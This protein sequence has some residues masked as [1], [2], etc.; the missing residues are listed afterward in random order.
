MTKARTLADITIPSGTPVG[1]TDTQ[2]LTNKTIAF[3][4]N[5]LTDVVGVTATQ[6]LTNKTLTAPT[7]ASANLTTALTVAGASGTSGQVLTSGGSGAAPTW[8]SVSSGNFGTDL[9]FQDYSLTLSSGITTYAEET[10]IMQAVSLDGT[11]ELMVL[12]GS[13]SAHAVVF[14]T[15]T[16]TFG[17]PVLVRTA[18]LGS[19]AQNV[20][21]AK[22]SSTSVLVCSLPS[23]NTGLET[24]VLTIS[25]STI[26]VGTPVST[27]LAAAS[28]L[29]SPNTRLVTV[30]SSY[31]LNYYN[32]T[33]TAPKFRAITV[34]GSTPSIGS[35]LA[36]AG[37]TTA[38]M[39][40][41][42]AQSAS[43]LLSF[44][45]TTST[46]V[47]V[48]PITV[49]GTTLTAGTAATVSTTGNSIV[50]GA[51]SNS[52]YALCYINTTG[53][54]AVVSVAGTTASISTAGTTFTVSSFAPQM[55]VFGNQA[56]IRGGQSTAENTNVITDTSGTATLGTNLLQG[57]G[58]FFVGYLSTSKVLLSNATS[59]DSD[60]YQ[61]G[62]SSGSPVLEKSFQN[63]SNSS[64][65]STN[66]IARYGRPLSGPP[67][68][69][70]GYAI[71][72][73]TSAGK[74]AT[75]FS[76]TYP[77]TNSIDGTNPPK[78]QQSAN[79]FSAYNDGISEAVAWGIPTS[80]AASTTAVQIRKVTLA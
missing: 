67:Q 10:I 61:Y 62:I 25:G 33:G 57:V 65:V 75:A 71:S 22:V 15:S 41:S 9:S 43:I 44:S 74:I 11:S 18:S 24:V 17:T 12:H 53:R 26:T 77:F 35:E 48:L 78:I 1:T 3:G 20:G 63:V 19:S 80:I 40:H 7:I 21:L 49:S 39:H 31:V 8:A 4:S 2:T 6:T 45:V 79:P 36:Y 32:T 27:T 47:F 28:S 64:V 59:G 23:S 52:R 46:T 37:G 76:S 16:N 54:G 56:F 38:N 5:T 51:L 30:G 73:R 60:Y 70:G 72:L 68:S 42:Y 13:A 58:C 14:N 50:T 69:A 29:I 66:G 55:Q 34:S